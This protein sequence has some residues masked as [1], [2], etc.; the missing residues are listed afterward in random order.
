[1][2]TGSYHALKSKLGKIFMDKIFLSLF[3]KTLKKES[4]CP[5][6]ISILSQIGKT[7]HFKDNLKSVQ[8]KNHPNKP[9]LKL[10]EVYSLKNQHKNKIKHNNKKMMIYEKNISKMMY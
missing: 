3:I 8:S 1:M 2:T 9:N 5:D 10:L 6:I 4:K 7:V